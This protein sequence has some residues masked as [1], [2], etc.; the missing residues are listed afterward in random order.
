MASATGGVVLADLDSD[1]LKPSQACIKP[2]RPEKSGG[3]DNTTPGK[4]T[5]GHA[6]VNIDERKS[7]ASRA[8]VAGITLHDCLSCSGCVTSSESV[9]ISSH[10]TSILKSSLKSSKDTV[11]VL[12]VSPH[13]RA[14]LADHFGLDL[15]NMQQLLHAYFRAIGF[16]YILDTSFATS[17]VREEIASEFM[18]LVSQRKDFQDKLIKPNSLDLPRKDDPKPQVRGCRVASKLPL[19]TSSCPGWVCYAEKKHPFC[20]PHI[21]T[22]KSPQQVMGKLIKL[23][24]KDKFVKEKHKQIYHVTIMPCYD[25]KLEASRDHLQVST[26]NKRENEPDVDLVITPIELISMLENDSV[27]ITQF[28]PTPFLSMDPVEIQFLS[29]KVINGEHKISVSPNDRVISGSSG[30]YLDYVF[31]YCVKRLVG[32]SKSCSQSLHY[33]EVKHRH[34]KI[35]ELIHGENVLLRF[36]LAYG[37]RNIKTVVQQIERQQCTFDFVEIMAC[38]DGCLNGGA[39]VRSQKRSENKIRFQNVK[40]LYRSHLPIHG[41]AEESKRHRL[42]LLYNQ[43][44]QSTPYSSLARTLFHEQREVL[45]YEINIDAPAMSW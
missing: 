9:L 32:S 13:A 5:A 21:S 40:Q 11:F 28:Q 34:F 18:Q 37:F 27:D 14:S 26:G 17:I 20:T 3:V 44:I 41:C 23:L 43:L 22:C 39:Q 19:L 8:P 30:G 7:V 31:H 6:Y 4:N 45:Q 2:I 33:K 24:Y 12:T 25:K 38:P 1:F 42:D 15:T 16:E 36:A 29:L 10:N 35:A